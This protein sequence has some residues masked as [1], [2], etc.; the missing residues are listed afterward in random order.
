MHSQ[1]IVS[2]GKPM[3][4]YR[5]I[6]STII[7]DARNSH[8]CSSIAFASLVRNNLCRICLQ[9]NNNNYNIQ[10]TLAVSHCQRSF[11]YKGTEVP[12]NIR[13]KQQSNA[14]SPPSVMVHSTGTWTFARSATKMPPERK[15]VGRFSLHISSHGQPFFDMKTNMTDKRYSCHIF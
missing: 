14:P 11:R 4:R 3:T 9:I 10:L 15:W 1:A 6:L 8:V 12:P 7:A 2:I 5:G 13:L